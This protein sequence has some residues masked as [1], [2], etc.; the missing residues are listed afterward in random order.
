MVCFFSFLQVLVVFFFAVGRRRSSRVFVFPLSPQES[1]AVV[2]SLVFGA[3]TKNLISNDILKISDDERTL[4]L[5]S[6][7]EVD[8][9]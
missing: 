8:R 7:D 4:G 5:V 2:G 6:V 9:E 1:L 3:K